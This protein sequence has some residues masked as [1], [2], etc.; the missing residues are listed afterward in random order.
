MVK[1]EKEYKN[2]AFELIF[3]GFVFNKTILNT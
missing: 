3:K 1:I 2:K